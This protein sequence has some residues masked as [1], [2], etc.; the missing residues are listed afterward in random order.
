MQVTIICT[1]SESSN[2]FVRIR[3]R[4]IFLEYISSGPCIFL[5][6]N[7]VNLMLIHLHNKITQIKVIFF[8]KRDLSYL[9]TPSR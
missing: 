6:K 9:W 2:A 7:T 4:H 3:M 8:V 1:L 5:Q